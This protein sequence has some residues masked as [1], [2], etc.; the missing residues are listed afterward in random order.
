MTTTTDDL[1]L[2]ADFQPA[3]YDDW[4]KLVDGV[5]KGGSFE[6]LV[7]K[8]YDGLKID[9]IYRRAT[10]ASPIAGRAAAAPW[11]VLQRVD[12]PDAAVANTQALN[13][14]ENGATGLEFEFAGGPGTRGFGLAEASKETLARVC[15]GI[16][17]DA[18]IMIA[19]NPVL[20]REN[21]GENFADMIEARKIDPAKLDLHFNYQALSTVAVRG[22][23]AAAWAEYGKPFGKVVNGLIKRGFKGPFVLAD[24]RPVHDAGGSEVQELAF[25]LAVALAYLRMLEAAGIELDAARAG[26]SFRLSADA[27]QFLTLAK[28]RALRRLWAR[29]E[30]A[31]GLAPKPIFVNAQ[32]AWRML[33]QRD[34]YVNM[35]RATMATFAAGLGGA[36]AITVLPHTLALGLPDDFARRV[37]RNTQ[38]VLLE[39]S[40]LAKVS[41]PAAGSGGVETLTSELCEAGWALFQEIEKAGGIFPALE[42]GLIQTKVAATRAARETNVAKRRDVLTGA[43]E[44]P[45][46]HEAEIAVLDVKPAAPVALADAKITFD[47]LA[48]MRLAEPFEALRDRSD[49][50]LKANGARPKIFLANLGTPADFTARATFAKSFFE[51]GGIEAIDSEGFAD[52]AALAAAFKASGAAMACICSSDKVYAISAA[53]AAKALHGAGAKHIYLAGRPGAQ[54]ATLRAA[55]IGE[56]VFAGGDALAT[57]RDA[58]RRMEQA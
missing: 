38:L 45:N 23:A 51:T 49:A 28:F 52:A 55:G 58:Y 25:T 33:T 12:H 44:F 56:F 42:Q 2:A 41:D 30:Q 53:E 35:L 17:L 57:L 36:N 47:A 32:T 16:H 31:C 20:G 15:D 18:G 39:E 3:T 8:T 1:R 26:I 6:K 5:L 14:L 34:A 29:V 48:P 37:A 43:S 22:A 24:G 9:P 21:A 46:L 11:Q 13:D 27:D 54:E 10:N 7:G 50:A 40:N 4:R 19:L